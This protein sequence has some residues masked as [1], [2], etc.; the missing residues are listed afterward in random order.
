MKNPLQKEESGLEKEKDNYEEIDKFAMQ[1]GDKLCFY[2]ILFDY[3]ESMVIKKRIKYTL[4]RNNPQQL[5]IL[6]EIILK[7]WI[8]SKK[9]VE[10]YRKQ[11]KQFI[12]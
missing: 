5:G 10:R 6:I 3:M 12:K 11:L 9:D 2:D 7:D 1:Y 4:E 8:K